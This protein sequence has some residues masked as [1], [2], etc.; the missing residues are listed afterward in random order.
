[1]TTITI[2]ANVTRIGNDAFGGVDLTMVVSLIRHPFTVYGPFTQNTYNKA[3]LYVPEGTY[4]AY[5]AMQ[6]WRDFM[7]IYEGNPPAGINAVEGTQNNYT[8]I[9]D[10]NGVRQ[11]EPKKGINIVNGKVKVLIK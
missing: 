6:G 4:S 9:Y 10:L 7:R 11:P 2:P 3:K 5:R 1:M 8:T